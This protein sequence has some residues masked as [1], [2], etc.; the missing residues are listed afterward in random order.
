MSTQDDHPGSTTEPGTLDVS[1]L[2]ARRV[3]DTKGRRRARLRSGGD[4]APVAGA[5]AHLHDYYFAARE[6]ADYG[7]MLLDKMIEQTLD[8]YRHVPGVKEALEIGAKVL[9]RDEE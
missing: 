9:L 6:S 3:A 2:R 1:A 7:H 5:L 8:P 4:T